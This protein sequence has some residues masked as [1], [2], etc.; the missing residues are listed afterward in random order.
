MQVPIR[1]IGPCPVDALAALL[2]AADDPVWDTFAVRQNR[3]LVHERTRSIAFV[4]G[5]PVPGMAGLPEPD[6]LDYAPAPLIAEVLA[7]A[8]RVLAHFPGGRVQRLML[9]ELPGG[10]AVAPHRD[11][12]RAMTDTHRCHVPVLTH[13]GVRFVIDG[14]DHHLAAGQIYEFDNMRRH[15]VENRGDERRIHLICNVRPGER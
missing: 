7:C 5:Q 10:Q 15:S 11:S 4:I 13:P 12:G 1:T 3:S 8:D 2:P 14:A 9:T 6:R